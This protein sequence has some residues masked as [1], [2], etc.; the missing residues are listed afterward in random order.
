M[1][2]NTTNPLT[3][4]SITFNYTLSLLLILIKAK[5]SYS[6]DPRYPLTLFM[7]SSKKRLFLH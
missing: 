3:A 7:P 2:S 6:L 4:H 1:L 5:L